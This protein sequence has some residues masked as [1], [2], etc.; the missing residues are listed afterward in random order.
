MLPSSTCFNVGYRGLADTVLGC[1]LLALD[2][3]RQKLPDDNDI[4]VFQLGLWVSVPMD[5]NAS[6][7]IPFLYIVTLGVPPKILDLVVSLHPV[8]VA[9]DQSG[10]TGS[11]EGREHKKM[12]GLEIVFPAIASQRHIQ[13]SCPDFLRIDRFHAS[14]VSTGD[15]SDIT[16]ARYLIPALKTNNGPPLFL[17]IHLNNHS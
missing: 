7:Q 15:G 1:K 10:R 13:I 3:L 11:D 9:S 5:S 2:A 8:V 4:I 6:V 16:E 12:D 14:P 17:A